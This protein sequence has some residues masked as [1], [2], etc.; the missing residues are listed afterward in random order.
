MSAA[1]LRGVY[2]T[3]GIYDLPYLALGWGSSGSPS[4]GGAA[5]AIP[6]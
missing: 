6:R 3:G 2:K 1:F 4:P 5:F